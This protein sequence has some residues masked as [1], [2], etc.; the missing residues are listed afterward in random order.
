M[1]TKSVLALAAALA[2]PAATQAQAA[3][4]PNPQA[5][6]HRIMQPPPTMD[7]SDNTGFTSLFDGTLKGWSY[8]KSL[9][10]IQDGSIHIKA[11]CEKPTG[12]VYAVSA[13]GEYGDFILKYELKGTGKINGGMQFRSYV[14][15]DASASGPKMVPAP[16]PAAPPRPPAAAGAAAA[17]R[18]PRPAE[19][20]NP[21]K[22][23]SKESQ[24]MYDM[25]GPQADFDADNHYSGMFYEQSG[26]AVIATPGYSMFADANGSYA[27]A[28]MVDKATHDS[29]FKK[30]DWNQFIVVAI[31]H[32][33]SIYMNGHLITQFVDTDPKYF[34]PTGKIGL[35]EESTGDLF[36][37]NISIR[38]LQ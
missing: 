1:N 2:I 15:G 26:R 3:E 32:S 5:G 19:C 16:R 31:G 13:T 22:P 14:T 20:A 29:W 23:P 6:F 30:D 28:H 18:A 10:D 7:F 8:D 9:W 36:A 25:A 24:A 4:K 38:K 27:V 37:R 12:T 21:G 17:P 35:E 11:T 33:T 34:R